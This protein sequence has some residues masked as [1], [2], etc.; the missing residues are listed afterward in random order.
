VTFPAYDAQVPAR[1]TVQYPGDG[2]DV[3]YDEGLLVGYR[4]YDATDSTPLFPFGY[5]LSYTSFRISNL[6]VSQRQ[7]RIVATV[8]VANTGSRAG[9]DVVQLYVS[10]PASAHEPPRQL[11]AYTK[12]TLGPGQSRRVQ[13]TVDVASLASWDNPSA[14]WT[15][16]KGTYRVYVGDSSRHLPTGADIT[17]G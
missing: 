17:I 2:S 16:R 7:G 1:S 6:S 12:V 4:W 11:K 5:G 9:A 14:G 15:V 8:T 13:L 3:Y 10:S